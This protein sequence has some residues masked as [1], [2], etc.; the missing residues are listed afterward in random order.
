[1]HFHDTLSLLSSRIY[2]G[3]G[4]HETHCGIGCIIK[5]DPGTVAGV[6]YNV[7]LTTVG[8]KNP[9]KSCSCMSSRPCAGTALHGSYYCHPGLVPGSVVTSR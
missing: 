4:L 3:I 7:I 5:T 6:G 9:V 2:S 8:R 1:M